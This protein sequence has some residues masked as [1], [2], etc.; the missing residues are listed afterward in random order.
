MGHQNPN[1]TYKVGNVDISTTRK[2]KHLGKTV[3]AKLKVSK[4]CAIAV[5]KANRILGLIRRNKVRNE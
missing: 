5:L 3:S 4:Q 2:G 1:L